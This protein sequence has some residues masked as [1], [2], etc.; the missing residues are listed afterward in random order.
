MPGRWRWQGSSVIVTARPLSLVLRGRRLPDL[1]IGAMWHRVSVPI[2]VCGLHGSA[3]LSSGHVERVI[4]RLLYRVITL[5]VDDGSR[6]VLRECSPAWL[7]RVA[8]RYCGICWYT[9]RR[10]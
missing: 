10:A 2:V 4:D 6:M 9:V 5:R 3:G 1:W 7:L 8:C